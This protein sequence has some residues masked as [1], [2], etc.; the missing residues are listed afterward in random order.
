MNSNR[1]L[2]KEAIADAKAVKDTAIANAKVALEEAFTPYLKERFAAK[3]AEID[4]MEADIETE[5][6]EDETMEERLGTINDPSEEGV[7]NA[8]S[9]DPRGNLEEEDDTVEEELDLEA[10]LRELEEG[11]DDEE[12]TEAEETDDEA[13]DKTEEE[14]VSLEDMTED[15]LRELIEDVIAGMVEAGELEAGEGMKDEKGEEE[16][17]SDEEVDIEELMAEVRKEKMKS[18]GRDE[19]EEAKRK[20]KEAE[21][22]KA[23]AEKEL[24]EAYDTLAEIQANLQEV[25]L[26]NA[27]LLY[28]NKVFRAKNLTESQK[29][30]VLEAFD[31]A[32]TVKETKLIYETLSQGLITKK[33]VNESVVRGLASKA[34][35]SVENKKPIFEVD[36]QFA[37]WQVLA[38]IKQNN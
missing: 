36:S 30:K 32:T 19:I 24:K 26:L 13:E 33:P 17:E 20:T 16:M 34:V 21:M 25:K 14:E 10:L 3:L 8:F 12:I 2:L 37:R 5:G 1:D 38:G 29:V 7:G 31:K 9:A 28:T 23:K 22:K 18:K 15:E 4:E 11:D 6:Y 35:G 27:K